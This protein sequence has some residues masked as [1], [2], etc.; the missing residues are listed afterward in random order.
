M[1]FLLDTATWANSVTL[2]EVLPKRVRKLIGSPDEPKGVCAVSLLECAILHRRGRLRLKGTLTD[3]FAA[4]IAADIQPLEMT[5]AIAVATNEL[6]SDFPGDPF[7]RTIAATASN[8]GLTLI[9]ADSAIRDANFC[10]VVYY[11]F[12]SSGA[13]P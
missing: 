11:P 2:P 12:K 4:A 13:K 9:T 10:K 6:P 3:F 5:P 1:R 7:D 8:L